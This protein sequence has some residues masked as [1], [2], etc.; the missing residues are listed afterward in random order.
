MSVFGQEFFNSVAL[1]EAFFFKSGSWHLSRLFRLQWAAITKTAFAA[2]FL[3][4]FCILGGS[5]SYFM[6]RFLFA[7]I[8]FLF[9]QTQVTVAQAGFDLWVVDTQ[10]KGGSFTLLP[11]TAK[12]LTNRA[13]Y[14]NQPSFI[15]DSELVFSAADEKG[16]HDII[17]Y[18]FRKGNF[19]NFS[20]TSD[21][22]EFSPTL[23]DCEQYI[24]AVVMEPDS[25]QRLWLYPVA[26]EPAEL[27]YD[28][29]APVGYYDWYDNRAAM[30]VLG[31][32]N[33]L[34]YA[35]GKGNVEEIGSWFGRSIKRRPGTSEISFIDLNDQKSDAAGAVANLSSF[36]LKKRKYHDLGYTLPDSQDFIWIDKNYLLMAQGDEIFI[37]KAS[38][39]E[40]RS[41]GT[42]P[43]KTH[44]TITRMAYSADLNKLVFVMQRN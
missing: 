7:L 17:L 4:S 12:P 42:L 5:E 24:S 9:F 20:K 38:E 29:I 16:N 3:A 21:R 18:S 25:T 2:P 32:P 27:L 30:F 40:W 26:G 13:E 36:D 15:N 33:R 8:P 43:S 44:H 6:P 11:Q 1:I 31:D 37:K 39:N 22:S 14:D 41:L 23:T 35:W 19:S 34:V 28:D 10:G